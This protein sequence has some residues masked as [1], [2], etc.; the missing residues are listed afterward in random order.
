MWLLLAALRA[1][2]A[3]SFLVSTWQASGCE[4]PSFVGFCKRTIISS[5]RCLGRRLR[6]QYR[7]FFVSGK[8]F[9]L[10]TEKEEGIFVSFCSPFRTYISLADV[11]FLVWTTA[12]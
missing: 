12:N 8:T 11:Y 3:C 4:L 9:F 2:D 10:P 5:E 7:R 6:S 1:G